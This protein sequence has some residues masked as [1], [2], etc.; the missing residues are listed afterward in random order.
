MT[1][2]IAGIIVTTIGIVVTCV[3]IGQAMRK[4]EFTKN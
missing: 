1:L 2:I 3:G 4:S